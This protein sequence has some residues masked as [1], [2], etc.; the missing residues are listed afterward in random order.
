MRYLDEIYD[1][2]GLR[3]PVPKTGQTLTRASNPAPAGS[4][5][6]L[7][8]GVAW[9]NPRFTDNS[10]GTVTD[11]LTGLIWLKNANCTDMVG[12]IRTAQGSYLGRC[13][14]WPIPWQPDDAVLTDGSTAGQ[15]RLPNMREMQSLI[16]YGFF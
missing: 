13:V 9:P 11:N 8:K 1:L 2:A 14:D 4:D 6:A 5:G 3:A 10:N 15:W 12:G 7:Q 16:H